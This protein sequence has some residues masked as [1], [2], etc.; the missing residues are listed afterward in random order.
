MIG[1]SPAGASQ[2]NVGGLLTQPSNIGHYELNK[3]A[4]VPEVGVRLGVQVTDHLRLYAGYNF[5]YWSNVVRPAD[6]ID[7]RVNGSQLPPRQ[8]VVGELF[9]KFEPRY[10]DFW[11][12]GLV[13]GA[14]IRY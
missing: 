3:F 9:P 10:S 2:T 7:L 13:L 4:V 1:N 8:N 11:A 12:H 5:T 6:V 14:Q